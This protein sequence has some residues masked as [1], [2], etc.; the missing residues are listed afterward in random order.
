MNDLVIVAYKPKPGCGEKLLELLKDHTP[1]LRRL[2]L[3]TDRPNHLMHARDG[4]IIEVFEWKEGA[5]AKAH[6]HPAVLEMWKEYEKVCDYTPLH[7]VP[8][9]HDLFATFR[10]IEP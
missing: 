3:A 10:P 9:T 1:F 4:T 5:V 8:E 7:E 2:G 6:E